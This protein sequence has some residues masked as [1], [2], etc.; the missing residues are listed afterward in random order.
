MKKYIIT[1]SI[2]IILLLS[3]CQNLGLF[4]PTA[5]PIPP[6]PTPLPPTELTICLGTEP[7]SLY[8]YAL[9]SETARDI[10]QL[11]YSGPFTQ[12][13]GRPLQ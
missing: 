6:T 4:Q 13:T 9:S 5:T 11:I 3:A 7:D 12:T 2:A 1:L 8:P 10:T